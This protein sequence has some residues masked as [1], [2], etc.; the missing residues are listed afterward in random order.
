MFENQKTCMLV[1]T[2]YTPVKKI[3]C[4]W[5]PDCILMEIRLHADGNQIKNRQKADY[6]EL[7]K[8]F[9]NDQITS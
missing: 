1:K 6:Y 3:A 7:K 9:I 5:K 8:I 2:K 4:R